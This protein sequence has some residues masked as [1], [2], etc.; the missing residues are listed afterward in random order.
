MFSP[1]S[2]AFY[3]NISDFFFSSLAPFTIIMIPVTIPVAST[4][5]PTVRLQAPVE[6]MVL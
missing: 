3:I 6:D 2:E 4:M 5:I 1:V